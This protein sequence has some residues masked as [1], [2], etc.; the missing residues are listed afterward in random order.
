MCLHKETAW[1]GDTF[2]QSQSNAVTVQ[3]KYFKEIG[4]F[5]L[6]VE[7]RNENIYGMSLKIEQ[8]MK[9]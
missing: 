8:G 4:L 5:Q 9:C 3:N 6:K 7:K 2:H 1:F